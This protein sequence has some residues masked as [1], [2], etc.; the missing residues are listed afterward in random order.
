MSLPKVAQKVAQTIFCQIEYI[1]CIEEIVNQKYVLC[2]CEIFK[3]LPQIDSCPIG[4]I[5]P[6]LITL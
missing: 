2:T 3:K 1:T 4:K 6:I 5:S